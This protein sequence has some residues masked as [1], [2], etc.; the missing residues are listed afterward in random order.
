MVPRPAGR[1]IAVIRRP[2]GLE[3]QPP[4][5]HSH[6]PLKFV[7][8]VQPAQFSGTV[9][10]RRFDQAGTFYFYCANHASIGMVGKV[11]VR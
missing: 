11:T 1:I 8:N 5:D 6:H 10:S 4:H 9:T 2:A 7:G 3:K